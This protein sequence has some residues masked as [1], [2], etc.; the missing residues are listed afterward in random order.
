MKVFLASVGAASAAWT[1]GTPFGFVNQ[2][3]F[4]FPELPAEI[5]GEWSIL[6]RCGQPAQAGSSKDQRN[7]IKCPNIILMNTDDMSWADVSINNPSKQMPT[8]NI[9][10]LVSKAIWFMKFE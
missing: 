10:R 6:E 4:D 1:P 8:P 7:D 5:A 3:D 2:N 9:D